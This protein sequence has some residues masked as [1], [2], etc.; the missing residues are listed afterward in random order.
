[1]A[2]YQWNF[3]DLYKDDLSWSND[4]KIF[5]VVFE[6]IDKYQNKLH[7]AQV[8]FE[9]IDWS[10]K[11]YATLAK[12]ARYTMLID[13]DQSNMI[14]QH[15]RDVFD[16]KS[17]EF[18]VKMSW[19]TNELKVIGIDKINSWINDQPHYKNYLK[20][21]NLLAASFPYVLNVDAEKLLSQVDT[22]R[23]SAQKLYNTL[24]AADKKMIM[25]E[26]EGV[27]KELTSSLYWSIFKK[28][29]PVLGQAQR[30]LLSSTYNAHL[31]NLKHSFAQIYEAIIQSMSEDTNIRQYQ[32]NLQQAVLYDQL[33]E[34]IF[35]QVISIGKKYHNLVEEFINL[36]K[37]YFKLPKFY[38]SDYHVSIKQDLKRYE[39]EASGEK[40]FKVLRVLGE[41]YQH[42]LKQALA[43]GAVDY[44]EATHKR[45]GAYS[46]YDYHLK[47]IILLNWDHSFDAMLTLTHE[48]GHSVHALMEQP[49]GFNYDVPL[50]LAETASII[51]ELLM[52]DAEY[53]AST[54]HDHQ[55][56]LLEKQIDGIIGTFFNQIAFADFEWHA[57]DYNQAQ[58]P[59]NA[60]ILANLFQTS[61]HNLGFKFDQ[62]PPSSEIYYWPRILHFFQSPFYTYKYAVA[63]CI[64]FE[65]FTQIKQGNVQN[66]IKFLK[67]AEQLNP[68]ALLQSFGINLSNDMI[69]LNLVNFLISLIKKLKSL[70]S[71]INE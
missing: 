58:K 21:F 11:F 38:K 67:N 50:V 8:F 32:S 47:P 19:V 15:R 62:Q 64:A 45:H 55:I 69:Y 70:L 23:D 20:H 17:Q 10:S 35:H 40:V 46:H 71:K 60:D 9:F 56:A 43:A 37:D 29:D 24:I 31:F 13:T 49:S 34:T 51:N 25:I 36:K 6:Q 4:L 22:S 65:F 66:F 61:M 3:A 12:L 30:Y 18:Y 2:L 1:M 42:A 33:D 39:I 57:H 63:I 59:L 5:D 16:I 48:A 54:S 7:N 27:Q 26:D 53:T 14:Y 28:S 44:H 41:E 52:F 68:L